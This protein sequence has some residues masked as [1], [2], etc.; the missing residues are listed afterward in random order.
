MKDKKCKETSAASNEMTGKKASEDFS[1]KYDKHAFSYSK[2][3]NKA[4]IGSNPTEKKITENISPID[5]YLTP[6]LEQI[7]SK[8]AR[9]M[10]REEMNSH[11]E[12]QYADNLFLGMNEE[13]AMEAAIRD[14]GD[15]VEVGVAMDR[16]HRPKPAVGMLILMAAIAVCSILIY[17]HMYS[18]AQAAGYDMYGPGRFVL[19]VTL[20]FAVMLILYR[21]DYSRIAQ[22]AKV[23]GGIFIAMEL[24]CCFTEAGVRV[25]GNKMWLHFGTLNISM[26][27][28]AFLFVPVFGAILYQHRGTSLK[29]LIVSIV[30]MVIQTILVLE[31]T[32]IPIAVLVFYTMAVLVTIA[33]YKGW[34]VKK[35]RMFTGLF[36]AI[37]LMFPAAFLSL[38]LGR[39]GSV[40]YRSRR[41]T[42]F[43][44]SPDADENYVSNMLRTLLKDSSFVGS[45]HAAQGTIF[46][47]LPD[48]NSSFILTWLASAYGTITIIAVCAVF[49]LLII[50]M[51]Q[52]ALKQKNQLGMVMGCGCG[53]LMLAVVVLNIFVNLS[54]LPTT[55]TF[56]PFFSHGGS[57]MIVC[58]A[59]M[60]IVMSIYRRQN[61]LPEHVDSRRRKWRIEIELKKD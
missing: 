29:G 16:I 47:S 23:I 40:V 30:W 39:E 3:K 50:W 41:L 52:S 19:H 31:C 51:F 12:E 22:F 44:L 35:R 61:V 7:R 5:Q 34:F 17:S 26:L 58:Y 14:M 15:P 9:E 32:S 1:E 36:W 11:I 55:T 25:N 46:E 49:A 60:G 53:I 38:A 54:L 57:G 4:N 13:K 6:L 48:Y 2:E 37:I 24:L 33:V 45:S 10:V 42:A 18:S 59:L 28:I 21:L 43:F 27:A 56:L 20:G 8:S